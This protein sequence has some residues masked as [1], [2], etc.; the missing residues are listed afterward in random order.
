MFIH[1]SPSPTA[2]VFLTQQHFRL[3]ESRL[4]HVASF[5]AVI[6]EN[7]WPLLCCSITAFHTAPRKD[8]P[9]FTAAQVGEYIQ[10]RSIQRLEEL[11]DHHLPIY[12]LFARDA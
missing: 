11:D 10:S 8:R 5:L 2:D 9:S 7:A 3:R 6:L 1:P 12:C 4:L